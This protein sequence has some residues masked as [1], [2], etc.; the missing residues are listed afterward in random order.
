M[1]TINLSIIVLFNFIGGLL[2]YQWCYRLFIRKYS[3]PEWLYLLFLKCYFRSILISF[4]I[5]NKVNLSSILL[6]SDIKNTN[7]LKSNK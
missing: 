4:F 7:P 6:V 5:F 2:S 3:T 1:K